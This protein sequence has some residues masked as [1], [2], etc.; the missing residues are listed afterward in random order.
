[1]V[2]TTTQQKLDYL[3]SQKVVEHQNIKWGSGFRNVV[4]IDGLKYQ[5]KKGSI[6]NNRLE[7]IINPLYISMSKSLNKKR[8]QNDIII[9]DIVA[10]DNNDDKYGVKTPLDKP[11]R[12]LR[13]K[14]Q[15]KT[16][17]KWVKQ[18]KENF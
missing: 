4:I 6:I 14:T 10:P 2:A 13:R 15:T 18:N 5:Y 17:Q 1:M 16:I 11:A 8:K 3:I 12:R 9:D 7:K